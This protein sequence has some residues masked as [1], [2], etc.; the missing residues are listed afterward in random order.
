MEMRESRVKVKL[1]AALLGFKVKVE[2]VLT[3]E[4]SGFSISGSA[5]LAS[6]R[7]FWSTYPK[8]VPQC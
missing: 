2:A 1:D 5:R 8:T 6:A 4:P 7:A 3:G